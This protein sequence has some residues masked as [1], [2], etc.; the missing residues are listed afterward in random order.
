MTLSAAPRRH[1]RSTGRQKG[2]RPADPA[3]RARRADGADWHAQLFRALSD[4]NRLRIIYR[5]LDGPMSV[6][7]L[8]SALELEQSLV[9]HHLATLRKM[10]L[11]MAERSGRFVEYALPREVAVTLD[12]KTLD[13]GCCVVTFRR[14]S[15]PPRQKAGR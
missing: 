11:V 3:S 4:P 10:S 5:L 12:G 14:S 2:G 9:S 1:R 6:G 13:L 15:T 8:T 7:E